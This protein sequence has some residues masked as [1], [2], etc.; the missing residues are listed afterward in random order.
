[1]GTPVTLKTPTIPGNRSIVSPYGADIDTTVAGT[2]RHTGFVTNHPEMDRVSCFI[3]T[4]TKDS[5]NGTRMMVAEW[6]GVARRDF[7]DVSHFLP[8]CCRDFALQHQSIGSGQFHTHP[9]LIKS[10]SN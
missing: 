8:T 5:F 4:K 3:Q 9:P 1:M 6:D 2:V 7:S 10:S